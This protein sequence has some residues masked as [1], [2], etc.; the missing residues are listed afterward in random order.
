MSLLIGQKLV[1]NAKIEKANVTFWL[2]FK[3]CVLLQYLKIRILEVVIFVANI[4][5][6][7]ILR[8]SHYHPIDLSFPFFKKR[9]MK[10]GSARKWQ[11]GVCFSHVTNRFVL[12][13]P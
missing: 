10:F 13:S 7:M 11:F 6:C 3:Y 12:I 4:Q 5:I 9:Q 2:I 1:E 8:H